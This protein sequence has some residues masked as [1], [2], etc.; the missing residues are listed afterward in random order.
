MRHFLLCCSSHPDTAQIYRNEVEA[1]QAFKESG[2]ARSDVFIT[3]KW[4]GMDGLDIPTSIQNSLKKVR[5]FQLRQCPILISIATAWRVLC[6][7]VSDPLTSA[8]KSGHPNCMVANGEGE[9]RRPC[10]VRPVNLL[11][12]S[13]TFNLNKSMK[14][15]R[16]Q[17]FW[18][19]GHGN[20]AQFRQ[21]KA[22]RESGVCLL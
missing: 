3:T 8:C 22:C 17:Q 21:D 16:D 4:S 7:P 14:E 12:S 1:G 15:Y 20:A 11:F 5:R 18:R 13:L 19:C 2:L 10:E 9:R 6:G